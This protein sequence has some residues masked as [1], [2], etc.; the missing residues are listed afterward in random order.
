M[1]RSSATWLCVLVLSLMASN[2]MSDEKQ[3]PHEMSLKELREG[4]QTDKQADK[5]DWAISLRPCNQQN[6]ATQSGQLGSVSCV[7]KLIAGD[8]HHETYLLQNSRPWE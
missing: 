7:E 5:R 8:D 2:A 1:W 6:A 4:N 3:D